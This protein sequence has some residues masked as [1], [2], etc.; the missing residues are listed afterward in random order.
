MSC[1]CNKKAETK[2]PVSKTKTVLRKIWEKSQ[3]EDKPVS[4]KKINK[5]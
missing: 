4:V 2:K 5:P 3:I 1:G